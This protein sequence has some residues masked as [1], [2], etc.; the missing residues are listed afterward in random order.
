MT[1]DILTERV[2]YFMKTMNG[3][4]NELAV[5]R[6][7]RSWRTRCGAFLLAA[8]AC[9]YS[10]DALAEVTISTG[11]G[12]GLGNGIN[13]AQTPDQGQPAGPNAGGPGAN[14]HSDYDWN[15]APYNDLNLLYNGGIQ[16]RTVDTANNNVF[17]GYHTLNTY[18]NLTFT[19]GG[20]EV[21]VTSDMSWGGNSNFSVDGGVTGNVVIRG[22]TL[23]LYNRL[24]VNDSSTLNVSVYAGDITTSGIIV[25]G[26]TNNGTILVNGAEFTVN[27]PFGGAGTINVGQYG[28]LSLGWTSLT[29]N[30]TGNYSPAT[31][32]NRGL[33][34]TA[35]SGV[36]Q[37]T[38]NLSNS[39]GFTGGGDVYVSSNNAATLSSLYVLNNT[40]VLFGD[41]AA[42]GTGLTTLSNGGGLSKIANS[43]DVTLNNRLSVN[44]IGG[45]A[46][47]I[48][49]L[50]SLTNGSQT[51]ES[52]WQTDADQLWDTGQRFIV[53][54]QLVSDSKGAAMHINSQRNE[55]VYGTAN[56]TVVLQADNSGYNGH[57]QVH[58]GVLEIQ[59]Q[60]NLGVY[61]N[62]VKNTVTIGDINIT[63]ASARA[64]LRV[65]GNAGASETIQDRI[66]LDSQN[67]FYEVFTKDTGV[68]VVPPPPADDDDTSTG[69]DA[70]DGTSTAAGGT[71]NAPTA[72]LAGNATLA[73]ADRFTVKQAGQISGRGS[74][75]K[76]GDGVLVLDNA[77]NIYT[78][79][80]NVWHG[81]LQIANAGSINN[82]T[83]AKLRIGG[84][85]GNDSGNFRPV[86]QTKLDNN[87]AGNVVINAQVYINGINSTVR[88]TGEGNITTFTNTVS[89]GVAGV[90]NSFDAVLNKD[91]A[92]TLVL[93][94]DGNW[95]RNGNGELWI[96]Q[97]AV[98]ISK[99]TNITAGTI[100]IGD[101]WNTYKDI[102]RPVD[103]NAPFVYKATLKTADNS[104]IALGNK[105]VLNSP[106]PGATDDPASGSYIETGKNSVLTV[107]SV[108]ENVPN[109]NLNK[110]GSGKLILN[111]ATNSFTGW[112]NVQDGTL[113]AT[114]ADNLQT[115]KG[116]DLIGAGTVFDMSDTGANQTLHGL[117]GGT[118]TTATLTAENP[119]TAEDWTRKVLIGSNTLTLDLQNFKA[120][121]INSRT[122]FRGNIVGTGTVVKSG[123]SNSTFAS[124]FIGFDGGFD[125]RTGTLELLSDAKITNVAGKAGSYI[126]VK[127][128][129]FTVDINSNQ[130][131]KGTIISTYPALPYGTTAIR[132]H[133]IKDGAGV[134]T[135][136]FADKDVNTGQIRGYQGDLT[137]LEG[138]IVST[139]DYIMDGGGKLTL[140]LNA[141]STS[142]LLLDVSGHA[143]LFRPSE[144]GLMSE[145]SA[146]IS[147]AST[148]WNTAPGSASTILAKILG[149]NYSDYSGLVASDTDSLF[150]GLDLVQDAGATW[151]NLLIKMRV[152]GFQGVGDTF[153]T[154]AV[155]KHLDAIRVGDT[156]PELAK[157]LQDIWAYGSNISDA[158]LEA[159]QSQTPLPTREERVQAIRG[160]FQQLSGDTI[161]NGMFMGLDKPWR[162]AFDRLNLDSQMVYVNPQG[163]QQ[164]GQAIA[165]MR[166]LWFTPTYQGVQGRSDGN[167]R[168]FGIDRPGY[169]LG[170]DKRVAQNASLGFLLGYSTPKLHQGDDRIEA[171]D[172]QFGLYGGAMVGYY[173]EMK[174]YIGFGHQNYKSNRNIYYD[175]APVSGFGSYVAHGR[176]NGDTFNFSFE[177]ARPLFLGFSILRPTIGLDSEHAFR[178][179]FTETGSAV[180]VKYQRASLSRTRARFGLSLETTTLDRAIFTGRLGYSCL[181]G[182]HDYAE[183]TGTFV[184]TSVPSFTARSV[185][186]GKS[187]FEAGVGTRIFLNPVKTL[188]LVGNYDATV[189]NR[190]AE[191]QGLV[192]FT[193][194]Y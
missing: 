67:A 45:A 159:N 122:E 102:E 108:T 131:Y 74:L 54:G 20:G 32:I 134:L 173:V 10:S 118:D 66:V 189:G 2:V 129:T 156:S 85:V 7:K 93:T 73:D 11:Q 61:D 119:A 146:S 194:I 107:G 35:Y 88:T 56:G 163:Q 23:N 69:I 124:G 115:A 18:D 78:G 103:A 42:L 190:W 192:G 127:D 91:G 111:S 186:V 110:S 147:N 184:D 4:T 90:S 68:V 125:V 16:V 31:A 17:A 62:A 95:G 132:P 44:S 36:T 70:D 120:D 94:G 145:V 112:A 155:G 116:V 187:Y 64:V 100:T 139:T 161:A 1:D 53:A 171:S 152:G 29:Q 98:E 27:G 9:W 33:V 41:T 167:A 6:A 39:I 177:V 50:N 149:N 92:G 38:G 138:G 40:N 106:A 43:N 144:N 76:T 126:D 148:A 180:A 12:R 165:N 28:M 97:G 72:A 26:G 46:S 34:D 55:T 59:R 21:H 14:A 13:F 77:G 8:L 175:F 153:N 137:I 117:R 81:V 25:S 19:T 121:D 3:I 52:S 51:T 80:T 193:Y 183:A 63:D 84:T 105:V 15:G 133:L 178:Y 160:L 79:D 71:G 136:G 162:P 113:A 150:Y 5:R 101:D 142:P 49:M 168:K 99:A 135:A 169:K 130:E 185:A 104:T 47:A 83:G 109:S 30:I 82:S 58:R 154:T 114:A 48:G 141:N 123:L 75:N 170:F 60:S 191:N 166:N 182:G 151:N 65:V 157:I 24:T 96:H 128:H 87:A 179:S 37:I 176:Y 172:F 181:L 57:Y 89:T 164:R 86:F 158:S 143:A 22:G 174:G 188:A 140:G